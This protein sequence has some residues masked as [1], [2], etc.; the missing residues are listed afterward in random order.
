MT[1]NAARVVVDSNVWIDSYCPW[2]AG[3]QAARQFLAK[4]RLNGMMLFYPVH[5]MKDVVYVLRHEYLR[6]IK[7][8]K[9][10]VLEGDALAVDEIALACMRNM[11]ELATAV[12]ADASDIWLANKYLKI[13]KDF[14]DN[15]LLAACKRCDADYLVTSDQRLINDANV[16]SKTP[17]QMLSLLTLDA[18]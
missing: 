12:G 14:E 1:D 18:E 7:R 17:A 3:S 16:L 15:M 5:V 10:S 8:A 9:G 4:A 13:H 2:H 11:N 6:D